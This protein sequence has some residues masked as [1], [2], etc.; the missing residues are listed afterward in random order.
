[1]LWLM[2]V[3]QGTLGYSLTSV[4]GAIPV[5]SFAGRHSTQHFRF[6]DVGRDLRRRGGALGCRSVTRFDRQLFNRLLALDRVQRGLGYRGVAG[7]AA[8]ERRRLE[9]SRSLVFC[10]EF[11]IATW[12]YDRSGQVISL[13]APGHLYKPAPQAGRGFKNTIFVNLSA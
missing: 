3:A 4:M 2:V 10:L 11:V 7:R 6:G 8:P 12:R 1:L 5:E 13:D 9:I